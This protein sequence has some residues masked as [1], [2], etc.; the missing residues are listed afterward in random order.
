[1][2]VNA[3]FPDVYDAGR[4]EIENWVAQQRKAKR[5]AEEAA[6]RPLVAVDGARQRRHGVALPRVDLSAREIQG[7]F[8]TAQMKPWYEAGYFASPDV[9]VRV[10]HRNDER[11][12]FQPADR[13]NWSKWF[14]GQ[15]S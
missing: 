12:G 8:T 4:E 6:A 2:L 10:R 15:S 5:A 14:G 3:G 1:V 13:V 11:T 9:L 7:P